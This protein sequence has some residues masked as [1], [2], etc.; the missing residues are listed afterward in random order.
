MSFA[1]LVSRISDPRPGRSRNRRAADKWQATRRATIEQ[2]EP[3]TVLS[4]MPGL[5]NPSAAQHQTLADLPLAAQ[6]AISSAIAQDQAT[7]SAADVNL[8]SS[9]AT[10]TKLTASDGAAKSFFGK[11]VS[12]SDSTV[13]VGAFF[14]VA[15][16]MSHKG[17][18]YVFTNS[19]SGWTQVAKLTTSDGASDDHF[20]DSVSISGNTVVVGA[21]SATVGSNSWQG[22]AYVFSR[23]EAGWADMTETAKLTASDGATQD[24]FGTSVSISG[25]TIVVG[26]PRALIGKYYCGAAYVFT[27][28]GSGWTQTAKLVV[29][30]RWVSV[31]TSVSISGNTVVVGAPNSIV[32]GKYQGTAFVFMKSGSVWTRTAEL[33]A[34]DGAT[35]SYFGKSVSISGNT[36]VVTGGGAV[37]VFTTLAA[38]GKTV[39]QSAK[40]TASDAVF[41]RDYGASVSI[42]GNTVVVK[43]SGAA[44]VFTTSGSGWTQTAKLTTSDGAG[45]V[46]ISGN[47]VVVGAYSATVGSNSQ[48]GAAYVF[49]DPP[50]QSVSAGALAAGAMTAGGD[51]ARLSHAEDSL[52]TSD[53]QRKTDMA[54]MAL[55]AVFAQ[56]GG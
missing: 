17:A 44:Y 41:T 50:P 40:L 30:D 42:S 35:D 7:S 8:A 10:E 5:D 31:G 20:G 21:H 3:R 46:S 37:Y 33:N 47:T 51:L 14:N 49:A 26:S 52:G 43:A 32:R 36:V 19:E 4:A 45:P 38:G 27:N 39:T 34:S 12:I 16:G 22:A 13:V 23:P 56:Y 1:T 28:P 29:S 24:K 54:I 15:D 55:E 48:Q 25:N 18:A 6:Q 53:Q 11:S 2:L 9:F